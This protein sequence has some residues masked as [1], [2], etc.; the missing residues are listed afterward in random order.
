MLRA[1]E[2]WFR[3]QDARWEAERVALQRLQAGLSYRESELLALLAREELTYA[4]I[5]ESLSISPETVRTH[6]R[7]LGAKLG[8]NGRSAVVM[9]ARARRLLPPPR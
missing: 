8:A 2:V 4:Q 9:A 1:G 5:A 6:V 3:R 7:H